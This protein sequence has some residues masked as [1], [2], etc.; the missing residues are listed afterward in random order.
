MKLPPDPQPIPSCFKTVKSD[1]SLFC[2]RAVCDSLLHCVITFDGRI[3]EDRMAKAVRL[4]L[5]AEPVLGCRFVENSRK[6]YWQRRDD[7]DHRE[8]CGV[9]ETNHSGREVIRFLTLPIDP[10]RDPQVQARIFRDEHDTLCIKIN[11]MVADAGG[12]KEYAYLLAAIYR[13]LAHSPSYKPASNIS[14]CRGIRQVVSRFGLAAKLRMA[15]RSFRDWQSNIRPPRNWRMPLRHDGNVERS[16]AIRR[17]GPDRFSTL[18]D[19]CRAKQV[20]FND[21]LVAACYRA[22]HQVIKP[23]PGTPLRLGT[24]VDLRRYLPDG[25]G[26]TICN[27]AGFFLLNI[28]TDLGDSFD[29]AL[30][31]VRERM[32][33]HKGDCLGLGANRFAIFGIDAVPFAWG[34]WLCH[35]ILKWNH[36]LSTKDVPPWLTNM[37]AIDPQQLNFGDSPVRDSFLSAPLAFPPL[38][39]IGI[40]GYRESITISTGFCQSAI[41]TATVELLL[42]AIESNLVML[43]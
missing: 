5:D 20:T 6:P 2:M 33:Q 14:G 39:V 19:Y 12:V 25:K 21:V 24:T 8:L 3:D 42:D 35:L 15:R 41:D 40:S 18:K 28:G 7:L 43:G 30:C 27:L 36:W 29:D 13:Q 32:N 31:R 16:F 34:Q 26:E 10:L 23:L 9:T 22:F 11:H 37:G 38:F 4:T 17:I 1:K